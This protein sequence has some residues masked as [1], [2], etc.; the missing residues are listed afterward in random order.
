MMRYLLECTRGTMA[1]AVLVVVGL[2]GAGLV[3][4]DAE[5]ATAA[6]T[7]ADKEKERKKAPVKPSWKPAGEQ[8]KRHTTAIGLSFEMPEGWAVKSSPAAAKLRPTDGG[9]APAEAGSA[10]AGETGAEYMMV[11]RFAPDGIETISG[12][13]YLDGLAEEYAGRV[14]GAEV[15]VK[16]TGLETNIGE[17]AVVAWD[18]PKEA[19]PKRVAFYMAVD[20]PWMMVLRA[21]G[22]KGQIEGHD[23]ALRETLGSVELRDTEI[24]EQ[25][26]GTWQRASA[27][28]DDGAALGKTMELRED[29]T[30]VITTA[31][32]GVSGGTTTRDLGRWTVR[33]R[34]MVQYA[35]DHRD[36]G[37]WT[38]AKAWR[39]KQ[40]G[41]VLVMGEGDGAV[42]WK[43]QE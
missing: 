31:P 16:E 1:L 21:S 3:G 20:T 37:V 26:V 8:G 32:E 34:E 10:T 23:A 38:A 17:G 25:L 2:L 24:D 30:M 5:G 29:G 43:R 19:G 42:R 13:D 36:G 22:P 15:A 39:L 33:G 7:A 6:K 18:I 27:E 35:G 12:G 28:K 40:G 9:M 14:P 11:L 41:D 4:C